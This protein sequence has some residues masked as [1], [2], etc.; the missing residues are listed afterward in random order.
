MPRCSSCGHVC[1]QLDVFEVIAE[2]WNDSSFNP[3]APESDCHLD[4]QTATDCLYELVAGL[5]LATPQK[6]EDCL[7]SMIMCCESTRIMDCWERSGQG[8]GGRDQE[9]D[10]VEKGDQDNNNASATSSILSGDDDSSPC[11]PCNYGSLDKRPPCAFQSRSAFLYG[12]P[13]YL[14]IT[15]KS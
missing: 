6:I 11:R 10:Q 12:N 9:E 2:L 3:I 15:G 5:L 1:K 4:Y 13:M 14:C 8:E 7:A